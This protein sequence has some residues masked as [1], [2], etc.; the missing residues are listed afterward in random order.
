MVG[1]KNYLTA[2]KFYVKNLL[3]NM[4]TSCLNCQIASCL[5]QMVHKL[6]FLKY[7]VYY[8]T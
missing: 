2:L 4:L 7:V 6:G 1:L 5:L 3:I 8:N